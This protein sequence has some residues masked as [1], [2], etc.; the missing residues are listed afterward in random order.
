MRLPPLFKQEGQPLAVGFLPGALSKGTPLGLP[1]F[2]GCSYC[3][4][5]LD[6]LFLEK[7]IKT[8]AFTDGLAPKQKKNKKNWFYRNTMLE[9]A[10]SIYIKKI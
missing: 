5:C 6:R 4:S 10:Y 8:P 7:I 3:W 2:P 9:T 1:S